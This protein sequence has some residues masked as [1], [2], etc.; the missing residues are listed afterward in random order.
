M[1][2]DDMDAVF[3]ALAHRDRR[4]I[5][6]LVRSNP[7]CCPRDLESAFAFSRIALLKHLQVL[8][9]AQLLH[10]IKHG[11]QRHLYLNVVPIQLI[12]ER[13]TTEWSNLWAGQMTRIKYNIEQPS[14]TSKRKNRHG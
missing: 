2:A 5:L 14:Q 4:R 6:D 1:L 8:E 9:R 13:W 7:G 10:S 3:L 12:Y 11:R